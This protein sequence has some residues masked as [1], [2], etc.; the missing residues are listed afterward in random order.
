LACLLLALAGCAGYGG[1]T[2]GA[3]GDGTLR[4]QTDGEHCAITLPAGWTW[5]PA[6]WAARS[7]GGT[8][9]AFAES[10]YG[11][12]EYPDWEEARQAAVDDIRQRVP[13][14]QITEGDDRVR[15]DYGPRAGLTILQRFDRV[16]CQL[17]FT[18]AEDTRQQE[19]AQWEEIV[20]SL[21]RTSPT[22]GYTPVP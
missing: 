21:T 17:T 6:S 3:D 15:I 13:D 8:H 2:A 22:P 12:P 9:L 14:A 4:V 5:L 16:G 11:R 10:L 19:E 18:N 7:P 1:E 20:A